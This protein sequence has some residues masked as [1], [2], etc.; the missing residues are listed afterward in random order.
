MNFEKLMNI[1][2]EENYIQRVLIFLL[3]VFIIAMNY[4]LLVVPNS[5]V[6]GGASGVA[7][8]LNKLFG[9]NPVSAVYIISG[10]LLIFSFVFLGKRESARVVVG[11][12]I[13]PFMITLVTPICNVLLPYFQFQNELVSV[14]LAGAMLGIGYGLIY[15]VG[16]NTG[17]GDIVVKIINK[18]CHM[19]EGNALLIC[20]GMV[21]LFGLYAFG[22][23]AIIYAVV[24]L[25]IESFLTDRIMIGISNSKMYFIY[26][27]KYEE[28]KKYLM[29]DLM[30]G[31][32]VFNTEGAFLK[33]K[34]KMLMVVVPTRDYYRVRETILHI[35]K[36][37]FF[38]VSDC[39]EVSG[40]KMRKNLPF[41]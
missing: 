27:E 6:I 33:K 18:Y 23:S 19:T 13:Y 37:A 24:I 10:V 31:V 15:K 17:G 3:G 34:R 7:V 36:E 5:F 21:L 29:K 32:T 12:I 41:I 38:V 39:Y 22:I 35:D 20:N 4:N 11:S 16:F 40:G 26:S 8:I 2:D 30:T 9:V 14:I 1:I 28:I 25:L